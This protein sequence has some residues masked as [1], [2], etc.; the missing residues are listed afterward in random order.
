MKLIKLFILLAAFV[1]L[2]SIPAYS[3]KSITDAD[4]SDVVNAI[5]GTFPERRITGKVGGVHAGDTATVLDADKTQFKFRFNGIDAPAEELG[6][7]LTPRE[8]E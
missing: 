6:S 7:R 5:A 8:L 4:F 2:F 1:S 3:Q